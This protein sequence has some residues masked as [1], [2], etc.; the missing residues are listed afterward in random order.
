MALDTKI[1]KKKEYMYVVELK[2]SIDTESSP[3]LQE[4]LNEIIDD[5]T[6][7]VV[8]DMNG[9]DY[10]SSA[11]ISAVIRTEKALKHKNSTF[12]MINLQPQIKKVFDA[13]KILPIV[14]M[15]DD[16]EEADQYIDH[17]IKEEICCCLLLKRKKT[18]C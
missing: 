12:A 13:M 1:I 5:K 18:S 6:K 8:L 7:A 4:E 11:G 9:V 16:M 2:G 3:D 17:I 10:I 14:N 15:F